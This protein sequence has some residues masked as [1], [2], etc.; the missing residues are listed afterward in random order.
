MHLKGPAKAFFG[1]T[2]KKTAGFQWTI[3]LQL[4]KHHYGVPLT[5][6]FVVQ[7]SYSIFYI[8]LNFFL[9]LIFNFDI[10]YLMMTLIISF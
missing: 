7:F 4:Y 5:T 8:D 3:Y 2:E 10:P 6:E 1:L 9:I